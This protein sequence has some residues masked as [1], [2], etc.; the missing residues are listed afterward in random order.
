MTIGGVKDNRPVHTCAYS[1]VAA[2]AT[3]TGDGGT[4]LT[5]TLIGGSML[6]I[7]VFLLAVYPIIYMKIQQRE[8]AKQAKQ[9]AELYRARHGVAE[10]DHGDVEDVFIFNIV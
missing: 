9:M 5:M 4:W 10:E 8:A 7:G 6:L 1:W 3:G 2:E